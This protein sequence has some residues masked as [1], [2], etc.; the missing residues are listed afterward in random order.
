MTL[1][2]VAA[3]V[4]ITGTLDRLWASGVLHWDGLQIDWA[5]GCDGGWCATRPF[6]R[7]SGRRQGK[8]R[9]ASKCYEQKHGIAHGFDILL[10]TAMIGRDDKA[11]ENSCL[12]AADDG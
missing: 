4:V 7:F 2:L 6:V 8:D 9:E 3:S 10:S 5:G 1:V 12:L 11:I